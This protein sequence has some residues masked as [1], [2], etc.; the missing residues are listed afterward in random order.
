MDK[1]QPKIIRFLESIGLEDVT[2]FGMDFELVAC[3]A[4]NKSLVH[5][6]IRK[7]TPWDYALLTEFLDALQNAS[8]NM[9]IRFVYAEEPGEEDISELF[10]NFCFEKYR[11][12]SDISVKHQNGHY[13]TKKVEGIEAAAVAVF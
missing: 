1:K 11:L 8:F 3:D 9:D 4:K 6:T 5:M 13:I 7:E 2:R 12:M 10:S